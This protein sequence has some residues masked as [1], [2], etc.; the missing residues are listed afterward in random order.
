MLHAISYVGLLVLTLVF[1][2]TLAGCTTQADRQANEIVQ[3]TKAIEAQLLNCVTAVYNSPD[4]APLRPHVPL[5]ITNATLEQLTDASNATDDEI[6]A[7]YAVYPQTQACRNAALQSLAPLT[8]TIVPILTAEFEKRDASLID[9]VQRK[10]TW[11]DHVRSGKEVAI[12]TQAQLITA[13][14]QIEAQLQQSRDAELARRQAAIQ[15]AA[16]AMAEYGQRQQMINNM[17]RP[18]FTNCTSSGQAFGNSFGGAYGNATTN[19]T[20]H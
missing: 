10:S 5:M 18:V 15:A 1:S 3:N 8:P 11:G 16:N 6:K 13:Y 14:Q 12:T 2:I 4:F 7:I 17:N 19:C 20:T 9:L